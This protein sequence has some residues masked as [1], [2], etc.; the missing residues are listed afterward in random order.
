MKHAQNQEE[1]IRNSFKLFNLPIHASKG[2][3]KKRYKEL[4]KIWHPDSSEEEDSEHKFKSLNDAYSVLL[5]YKNQHVFILKPD[6]H[7][8]KKSKKDL[9]KESYRKTIKA[10]LIAFYKVQPLSTSSTRQ[11]RK[12]LWLININFVFSASILL[13]SPLLLTLLYGL[14]GFLLSVFLIVFLSLFI[15]SAVRNLH[16]THLLFL[17]R[18]LWNR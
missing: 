17:I 14:D 10:R 12:D 8:L 16:R 15:M 3:I 5:D 4:A 2:V 7:Y 1:R 9:N 18:R 13:V 11:S 6:D